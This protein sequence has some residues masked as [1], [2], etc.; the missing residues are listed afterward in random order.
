[1]K[2]TDRFIKVPVKLNDTQTGEFSGD[3]W[4][5]FLPEEVCAYGASF[6]EDHD[7]DDIVFVRL[8]SGYFFT[9]YI[10]MREFEALLNRP[11]P[12]VKA[13]EE[14]MDADLKARAE[15]FEER[16]KKVMNR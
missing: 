16:L 3:S 4:V 11:D 5:K 10:T 12:Y 8:K 2:F 14:A 15:S 13:V 7:A 9:A 1:M 6:D